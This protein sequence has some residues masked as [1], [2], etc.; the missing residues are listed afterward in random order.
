MFEF[1]SFFFFFV[2][3]C[4][5]QQIE[6]LFSETLFAFII[7]IYDALRTNFFLFF[8]FSFVL[9]MWCIWFYGLRGKRGRR[10]INSSR[11]FTWVFFFVFVTILSVSTAN[12]YKYCLRPS[13]MPAMSL[14]KFFLFL[15]VFFVHL[16]EYFMAKKQ[17]KLLNE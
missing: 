9:Y 2:F 15:L 10:Y 17:I 3:S 7:K 8:H 5:C 16:P 13:Y 14:E 6:K 1:H 11:K 12:F 4:C